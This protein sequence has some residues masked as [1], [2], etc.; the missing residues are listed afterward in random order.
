MKKK[1]LNKEKAKV[2]EYLDEFPE[3]E[4]ARVISGDD[5]TR[6][7][8]FKPKKL[9]IL[10]TQGVSASVPKEFRAKQRAKAAVMYRD[11][12]M[13]TDLDLARPDVVNESPEKIYERVRSYYRSKDV[14]G[15]YI[16]V[17]CDLA[18]SGFENDC[19]D[20]SIK[21]FYD[22]WCEDV[23]LEQVLEWIFQEFWRSG[24]VRTYKVLGKYE[25]QT[26]TL[27]EVENP[28]QP[29]VP[30]KEKA[31]IDE[32]YEQNLRL[33]EAGSILERNPEESS[34][35]F[36]ERK[37][38]WSKGYIPIGYTI[39]NPTEIELVGP[40]VFNQT[41]VVLH[42]SEELQEL[43]KRS[44]IQGKVTDA[45]KK[46]LDNLPAEIKAALLKGEDV[47]LDPDFVGVIDNRRMP[48]EK[49]AIN[50]MV[51]ALE[52]VEYKEALREADYSTIDGITSEILVVTVGDKDFPVTDEEELEAVSELFNTAQKSFGVFWNHT[53]QVKR[54]PI[55][56][57]DQIFGA[58]KFEQAELDISGSMRVPR[59]LI[60]GVMIGS[61]SKEALSLAVKA[62]TA[63]INYARRQAVRWLRKEYL[64]IAEA[65]NFKQI[66]SVRW[67]TFILK[68]ELAMKTLL[69]GLA[70]R[71]IASYETILKLLGFDPAYEKKM[72]KKEAPDVQKGYYGI[73][74]SPYQKGAGDG[75]GGTQPTQKT[76]K[77][78]PSEGRPPNQPAPKTPVAPSPAGPTKH[79]IK[80]ETITTKKEEIHKHAAESLVRQMGDLDLTDIQNMEFALQILRQEKEKELSNLIDKEEDSFV[81]EEFENDQEV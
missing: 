73:L 32:E 62:L 39:L 54:L 2:N 23:D 79:I 18:I 50:P 33:W 26:N 78:T 21:E 69:Q 42:I 76:P 46:I 7:Y 10:K 13:R 25:P 68:D 45:E 14:F 74:G 75:G 1:E 49:Y 27:R 81:E 30:K 55:E 51:R 60:D 71:R 15:S 67:D 40:P 36:A 61:T 47:E 43:V 57:I 11:T 12:L 28:P 44:E 64:Q 29:D 8:M 17:L 37:K 41:R 34:Q 9:A 24:M 70:D 52:A 66:P 20:M 58:K 19:E 63:L 6:H 72:L 59:A 48:Y 5:G 4:L 22:N 3:V 53:L 77:G 56:N 31:D 16:D 65:Y 38:R 80:K 35:E